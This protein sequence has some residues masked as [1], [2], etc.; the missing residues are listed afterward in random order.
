MEEKY[1]SLVSKLSPLPRGYFP[2]F[3]LAVICLGGGLA[4]LF[5]GS[6]NVGSILLVVVGLLALYWGLGS[7]IYCGAYLYDH[8]IVVRSLMKSAVL[9]ESD[10]MAI[11]WD[12]AGANSI[13]ERGPRKNNGAAEVI[14]HGGRVGARLADSYY[15]NVDRDL[16]KWQRDRSIPKNLPDKYRN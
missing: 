4:W 11:T 15:E 12:A 10:M 2:P 5:G 7:V 1:G 13:N 16:G 9:P 6:V 3:C 14:M 8:A